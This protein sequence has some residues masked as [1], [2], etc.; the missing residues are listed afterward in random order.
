M[1][2]NEEDFTA[3]LGF[4][5]EGR[6]PQPQP[7]RDRRVQGDDRDRGEGIPEFQGRRDHAA[8]RH[9]RDEERLERDPLARRQ[10]L[11]E[12]QVSRAS[13]S[14][15]ASA[16]ATVSPAACSSASSNSTTRRR[17]SN[18][19][20]PTARSPRPPPATPPWPRA[21]KSKKRSA[22]AAPAWSGKTKA[23]GGLNFRKG[24][25]TP[26]DTPQGGARPSAFAKATADKPD[27]LVR[28]NHFTGVRQG[29]RGSNSQTHH[30][31]HRDGHG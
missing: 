12:P 28:P 4:E 23:S 6:G 27:A 21:R 3:S 9:H 2:G 16:A 7:H 29:N 14:S 25:L 10:I 19:A 18:T 13:K 24:T 22:A 15:T 1:I 17:P 8:P 5:V 26:G 31:C 11:R 20:R 30:R